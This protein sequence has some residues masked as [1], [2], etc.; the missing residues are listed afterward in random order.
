MDIEAAKERY[1][2]SSWK[3]EP[4]MN[5]RIS[6]ERKSVRTIDRN[7][8]GGY[9]LNRRESL[10]VPLSYRDIYIHEENTSRRIELIVKHTGDF[11]EAKECLITHLSECSAFLVPTLESVG[12]SVGDIGFGSLTKQQLQCVFICNNI[13]ITIRSI[14]EIDVDISAFAETMDDWLRG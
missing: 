5:R 12:V 9:A 3:K 4:Q 2:F 11:E 6:T 10:G 7:I 8:F 14:G 1:D 13:M